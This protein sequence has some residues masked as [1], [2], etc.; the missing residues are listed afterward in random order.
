M[1][2][3]Q[4]K[5]YAADAWQRALAEIF[6]TVGILASAWWG[7]E[8]AL[9]GRIDPLVELPAVIAVSVVGFYLS[10]GLANNYTDF[11]VAIIAA[12]RL[13][14]MMDQP[15]AVADRAGAG[16]VGEVEPSIHFRRCALRIRRRRQR[17]EP[18]S[19]RCSTA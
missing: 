13:F 1:Q 4:E 18:C 9:A 3:G 7:V 19:A 8:L 15:P 10:V 2:E 11:R 16:T 14:G 17:L 5:L 6:I 12:R